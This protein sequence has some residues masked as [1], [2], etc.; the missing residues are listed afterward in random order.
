MKA[1][2]EDCLRHS[3]KV[4]SSGASSRF[5][6]DSQQCHSPANAGLENDRKATIAVITR[7]LEIIIVAPKCE[8]ELLQLRVTMGRSA[9]SEFLMRELPRSLVV[10]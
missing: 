2:C 1:L 4:L 10:I 3:R 7:F 5:M 8:S 9:L 6:T